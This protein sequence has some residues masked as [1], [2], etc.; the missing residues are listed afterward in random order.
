[1]DVLAAE[2]ASHLRHGCTVGD[3][4]MRI[5]NGI[6]ELRLVLRKTVFRDVDRN[7]IGT[8]VLFK[9]VLN[10]LYD[11]CGIPGRNRQMST[12]VIFCGS[13]HAKLEANGTRGTDREVELIAELRKV[14]ADIIWRNNVHCPPTAKYHRPDDPRWPEPSGVTGVLALIPA[15]DLR[16]HLP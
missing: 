9:R 6:P 5:I 16:R 12:L 10:R 8:V 14:S 2:S 7:S 11:L 1:M 3:E 15:L 13:E 4:K